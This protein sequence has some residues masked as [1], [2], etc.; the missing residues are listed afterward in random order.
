MPRSFVLLKDQAPGSP[1]LV[2]GRRGSFLAVEVLSLK[3]PGASFSERSSSPM[4]VTQDVQGTIRKPR[5]P[6]K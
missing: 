1:R 3:A 4:V 5:L 2:H 6:D